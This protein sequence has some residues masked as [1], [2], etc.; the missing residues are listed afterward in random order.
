[1]LWRAGDRKGR[2]AQESRNDVPSIPLAMLPSRVAIARRI[3][4]DLVLATALIWLPIVVLAAISA[5]LSR[6]FG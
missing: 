4:S 5:L 2:R 1:M 6:L 3:V